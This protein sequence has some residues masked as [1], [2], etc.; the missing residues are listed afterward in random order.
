MRTKKP[1]RYSTLWQWG[2]EVKLRHYKAPLIVVGAG[3]LGLLLLC[4]V[5]AIA[6]Q[7]PQQPLQEKVDPASVMYGERDNLAAPDPRT[8]LGRPAGKILVPW[9]NIDVPLLSGGHACVI[10]STRTRGLDFDM[11]GIVSSEENR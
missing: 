9:L 8:E 5:S 1:I 3:A 4:S 11:Q 2:S 10:H 6:L 7:G